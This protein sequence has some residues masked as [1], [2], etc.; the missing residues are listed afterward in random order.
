MVSKLPLLKRISQIYVALTVL[1]ALLHI[2]IT[3]ASDVRG[4]FRIMIAGVSCL[5]EAFNVFLVL[6][7]LRTAQRYIGMIGLS[8]A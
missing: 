7:Y 1:A 8:L 6:I 5:T 2:I 3:A 4:Q